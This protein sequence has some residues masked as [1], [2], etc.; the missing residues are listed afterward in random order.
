MSS[1]NVEIV[2]RAYEAWNGDDPEAATPL[3]HPD[4]EWH[5]PEN[6]PDAGTWRGREEVVEGLRSTSAS[7]DQL[8]ADVQELIDAG[9]RV[10]ALVRYHGRA[11]ITGIDMAGV[12]LDASVWTV[13]DGQAVEVRMYNGT[14]DALKAVGLDH[15]T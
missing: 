2:R 5:L 11:A 8:R 3:L 10:V 9:E 15:A 6:F 13:V 1:E 4:I 14:T 7:W 12:H